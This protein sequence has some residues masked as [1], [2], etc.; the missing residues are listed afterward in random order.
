MDSFTKEVEYTRIKILCC[1]LT[2]KGVDQ[3]ADVVDGDVEL[4]AYSVE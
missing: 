1:A 4:M 2:V 3:D